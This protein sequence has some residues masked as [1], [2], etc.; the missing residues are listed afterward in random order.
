MYMYIYNT[1]TRL[2]DMPL[3]LLIIFLKVSKFAADLTCC[4]RV[5]HV[6]GAKLQRLLVP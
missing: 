1:V 6:L 5:F 3:Q 4:G 2:Q